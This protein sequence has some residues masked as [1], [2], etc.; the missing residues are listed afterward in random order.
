MPILPSKARQIQELVAR[1]AS[2]SA[3]TRDSAVAR[4]T[5]VGGRAVEA[6]LASLPTAGR[7]GRLSALEVLERLAPPRAAPEV[8]ALCRDRDPEV[9]VK[10]LR[11]ASA[12]PQPRTVDVLTMI[13]LEGAPAPRRAAASSLARIHTGG[14]V[15]AI[16]PLLDVLLDDDEEDDMRVLVFDAL[17]PLPPR[18][19]APL[20]K[21]LRETGSVAL[22]ARVAHWEARSPDPMLELPD[23][24][25]RKLADIANLPLADEAGLFAELATH[26]LPALELV[27]ERLREADV[28]AA[29]AMRL[30]RALRH[31]GPEAAG[32]VGEAL[33]RGP[34]LLATRAL[35]D[36]LA[37]HHAPGGIPPLFRALQRLSAASPAAS[38][39]A[40]V[41]EVKA[42]I[43]LA[44][45]AADSRIALYDLR[46]MLLARPGGA[47]PLLLEAAAR[48][49]DKTLVPA[50]AR[51]ATNDPPLRNDCAAAFAAIAAREKLRRSNA[52]VKG[53]R[54]EHRSAL[55][56]IWPKAPR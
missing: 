5:L 29:E 11:L 32:P 18:T 27:L 23:R 17:T 56:G 35:A 24:L 22:A 38:P 34:G 52:I 33:D 19:L 10:A 36:A 50:L 26:G 41:A 43:H 15:D 53:L 6:I 48:V 47:T 25:A 13:L 55:E 30:G 46:E 3:A 2:G 40:A 4:L 37:H 51:L 7:L 9:A 45:A 54:P 8:L 1:L 39:A 21:R 16:D 14:L 20:L 49:G 42:R 12:Y 28:G 44:L 31:F